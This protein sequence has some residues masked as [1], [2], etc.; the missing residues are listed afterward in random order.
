M[1][2]KI[3]RRF[4]CDFCSRGGFKKPSI[5][6]HETSCTKNPNRVCGTC[7]SAV[8]NY[9]EIVAGLKLQEGVD[10]QES[11]GVQREYLTVFSESALRWLYLQCDH[12]PTCVLSVLRQG[13]FEAFEIFDYK[14]ELID[15][16]A[17]Q[18]VDLN[19]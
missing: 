3:V 15:W 9:A 4:Y 14:Q 8:R 12:C 7:N 19:C 11:D 6:T 2:E 17:E 16:H 10:Q 5:Q 18:M 13:K 1:R